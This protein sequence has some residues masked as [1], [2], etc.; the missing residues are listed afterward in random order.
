VSATSPR[1]LEWDSN[2]FGNEIARLDLLGDG[3]MGESL[4]AARKLGIACLY[5]FVPGD[6]LD[7][8]EESVHQGGR[9][10]DVRVELERR[11]APSV[12]SA[13]A[14]G[15]A[16]VAD[17]TEEAL[18]TDLAVALADQ[19]RFSRDPRFAREQVQAMYRIWG[20]SCLE[21]GVVAL[22]GHGS[23]GLVG[24]RAHEGV[25]DVELVWVDRA[26]RGRG[27]AA[28]LVVAAL[29]ALAADVA[30]VATQAGNVAALR[31]YE[32]LGFRTASVTSI[33]HL[34]LDRDA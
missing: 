26:E 34:W 19:S 22:P 30:R 10:V 9:I 33:L 2:F 18:V 24:A 16:R 11:G 14:G 31:L 5:V 21:E 8:L 23:G 17:P 32:G 28:A 7:L 15:S 13:S 4:A 12:A 27:L 1:R 3:G 25:A 20:R 6:R 29:E